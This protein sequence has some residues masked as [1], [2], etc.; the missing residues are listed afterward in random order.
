MRREEPRDVR[1]MCAIPEKC[2]G[3][4]HS[5]WIEVSQ[6]KKSV[7]LKELGEIRRDIDFA[8]IGLDKC[9]PSSLRLRA[10]LYE[11]SVERLC[12]LGRKIAEVR[13]R[14]SGR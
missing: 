8:T 14:L 5:G 2:D 1:V 13:F 9:K 10:R 11:Q 3:Q 7:L 4:A 12:E 6:L